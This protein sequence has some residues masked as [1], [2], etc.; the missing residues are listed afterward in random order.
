MK[1]ARVLTANVQGHRRHSRTN[2][3]AGNNSIF[4]LLV[5]L[6][7]SVR[8]AGRWVS[9]GLR[10]WRRGINELQTDSGRIQFLVGLR[11]SFPDGCLWGPGF[12]SRGCSCSS[13]AFPVASPPAAGVTKVPLQVSPAAASAAAP[14]SSCRNFSALQGSCDEIGPAHRIEDN[15]PPLRSRTL[16]ASSKCF[17]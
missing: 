8:S 9:A 16:I 13:P 10:V 15:L 1:C 12:A 7:R 17:L 11:S 2:S 14:A 5:P 3:A 4:G 6:V